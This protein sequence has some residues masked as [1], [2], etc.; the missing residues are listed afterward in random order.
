MVLVDSSVWIPVLRRNP[1]A[2]L[3]RRVDGL[4]REDEA[5]VCDIVKVELLSGARTEEEYA[6]LRMRLD[7][8][9][10]IETTGSVWECAARIVFSMRR[11]GVVVPTADALV[12]ACARQ[13]GCV[14]LHADR[15]F[16]MI[17][18]CAGLKVESCVP[19]RKGTSP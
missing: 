19:A 4:L 3:R 11:G 5:A 12:A 2:R 10:F 15:H 17:A 14:L 8:L 7:A 9:P 13:A 1:P 18:A 6:C 16:D